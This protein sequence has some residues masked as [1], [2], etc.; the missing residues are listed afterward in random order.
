MAAGQPPPPPASEM[1]VPHGHH[2]PPLPALPAQPP[3]GE[4]LLQLAMQAEMGGHPVA[5]GQGQPMYDHNGQPVEQGMHPLAYGGGQLHSVFGLVLVGAGR[6]LW[7]AEHAS[8]SAPIGLPCLG[9]TGGEEQSAL[10]GIWK[11]LCRADLM[12]VLG[13]RCSLQSS[14]AGHPPQCEGGS[15]LPVYPRSAG[16]RLSQGS[17]VCWPIGEAGSSR[18]CCRCTARICRSTALLHCQALSSLPA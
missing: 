12:W 3:P 9:A 8:V 15:V 14:M 18:A 1:E 5:M 11:C 13:G 2:Q 17:M 10:C 4:A 7:E 6:L 16:G